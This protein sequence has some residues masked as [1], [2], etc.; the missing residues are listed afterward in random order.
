MNCLCK[1]VFDAIGRWVEMKGQIV[2]IECAVSGNRFIS[3]PKRSTQKLKR[4]GDIRVFLSPAKFFKAP[5]RIA[6]DA[7]AGLRSS[8]REGYLQSLVDQEGL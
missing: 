7:A 8:P 3:D 5:D 1:S 4:V 6:V 2:L